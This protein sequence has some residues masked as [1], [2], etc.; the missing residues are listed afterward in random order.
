ME[1]STVSITI[2]GYRAALSLHMAFKIQKGLARPQTSKSFLYF[3]CRR[4]S[5]CCASQRRSVRRHKQP[6][7]IGAL[8]LQQFD[9]AGYPAAVA[10]HAATGADAALKQAGFGNIQI[11][12][13]QK[14]WLCVTAEKSAASAR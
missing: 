1:M 10:G 2:R 13:H 8:Q 7:H 9:F 5:G 6:A 12:K 14:G 3:G 4:P 11:H